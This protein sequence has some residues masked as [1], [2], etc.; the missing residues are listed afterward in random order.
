MGKTK[1]N[2]DPYTKPELTVWGKVEDLTLTGSTNPGDD[3]KTGSVP[4]EGV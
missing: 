3:G 2:T 4:S 1:P